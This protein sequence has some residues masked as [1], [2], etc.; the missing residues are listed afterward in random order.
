MTPHDVEKLSTVELSGLLYWIE[1]MHPYKLLDSKDRDILLKRYS[2]KKLSLDHFY[3]ASKF[4][5]LIEVCL[6][7]CELWKGSFRFHSYPK[8]Y[9]FEAKN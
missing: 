9:R 4:P 5:H 1:K 2:V 8:N 6:L 3:Y 7:N